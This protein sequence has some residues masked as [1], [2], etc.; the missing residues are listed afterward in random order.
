MMQAW[1]INLRDGIE[2]KHA[3]RYAGLLCLAFIVC[4]VCGS[5]FMLVSIVRQMGLA[6]KTAPVVLMLIALAGNVLVV[7]Q[8]VRLYWHAREKRWWRTPTSTW[9]MA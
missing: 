9:R 2:T 3:R 7:G 6:G 5:G 8:L 1:I 4:T